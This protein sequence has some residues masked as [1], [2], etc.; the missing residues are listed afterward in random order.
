MYCS[1]VTEKGHSI[2]LVPLSFICEVL[3]FK[4]G[5]SDSISQMTRIHEIFKELYNTDKF[6]N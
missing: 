3:D 1:I 2:K 5:T 4:G 6:S